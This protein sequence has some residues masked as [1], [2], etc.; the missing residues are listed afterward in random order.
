[1]G[2][3]HLRAKAQNM[4][5]ITLDD[6]AALRHQLEKLAGQYPDRIA[7]VRGEIAE[8]DHQ[9]GQFDRDIE[10]AQ[11]VVAMTTDD[12][13]ELR[14]MVASAE[15]EA[16]NG[17]RRV[18]IRFEGTRFDIDQAYTEGR[19]INAVRGTYSD[20]LEHDRMQVEFLRE[21][22]GRLGEIL[23][24]LES[25]FD[26]YQAQLWQLDRQIDAIE[27]NERLIELT[28]KQ[29]ATLE[30]YARFGRVDN[31]KQV[32]AKLAELRTKQEAQLEYLEKRGVHSDYEKRAEFSLNG[33]DLIDPF[34]DPVEID[35]DDVDMDSDGVSNPIAWLDR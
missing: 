9:L 12:L 11:R 6:P 34:A 1:M 2:I 10:V 19:R 31:L 14:A 27:R 25:E 28:E 20:R 17:A 7:E 30:N 16:A 15:T 13:N 24:K 23:T 8:V 18:S 29:Q 22:K 33:S 21:Q 32:E 4:V 5:E 26:T 3:S 35:A